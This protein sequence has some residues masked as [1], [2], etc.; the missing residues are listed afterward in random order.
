MRADRYWRR[1]S[2]DSKG[3]SIAAAPVF[4]RC[5][6]GIC[7]NGRRIEYRPVSPGLSTPPQFSFTFLNIYLFQI[8]SLRNDSDQGGRNSTFAWWRWQS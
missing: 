1:K 2:S 7:C 4:V 6:A 5:H 8:S 3:V